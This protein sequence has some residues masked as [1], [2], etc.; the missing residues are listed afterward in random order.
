MR[1][2]FTSPIA[3]AFSAEYWR[4]RNQISRARFW[5]MLLL[6][7]GAL[8]VVTSS[9]RRGWGLAFLGGV[10][11]MHTLDVVPLTQSWPLFI[12]SAGVSMMRRPRGAGSPA[13]GGK[14]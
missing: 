14:S 11:L 10:L 5:P 13:E 7:A 1:R 8:F 12:V 4:Q 9:G 6:G 2:S 3:S